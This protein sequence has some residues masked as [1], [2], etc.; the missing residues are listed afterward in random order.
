MYD[1]QGKWLARNLNPRTVSIHD[2]D[3]EKGG[4]YNVVRIDG[5]R[6]RAKGKQPERFNNIAF[7]DPNFHD[8]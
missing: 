1:I 4:R 6:V 2:P 5:V 8:D 3:T 7:T